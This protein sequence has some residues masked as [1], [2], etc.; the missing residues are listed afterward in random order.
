MLAAQ[1]LLDAQAQAW[2]AAQVVAAWPQKLLALKPRYAVYE[3]ANTVNAHPW[4]VDLL[5]WSA[6]RSPRRL[7]RMSG[8]LEETHLPSNLVSFKSWMRLLFERG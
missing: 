7:Q 5:V 1:L 4:L 8:V 3:K 2:S 6:K